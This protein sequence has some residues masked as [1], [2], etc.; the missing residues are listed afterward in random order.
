MSLATW[1]LVLSQTLGFV[2][3]VR[4]MPAVGHAL[5]LV[6]P[7]AAGERQATASDPADGAFGYSV[8]SAFGHTAGSAEC[9]VFDQLTHADLALG[10]AAD[11][12]LPQA[13]D[14]RICPAPA[15]A[16][17]ARAWRAQARGPPARA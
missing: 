3:S 17:S 2:H 13:V 7:A 8:D 16:D 14:A 12:L 11:A 9:R 4:H 5:A 10:I 1:L 15:S 6:G